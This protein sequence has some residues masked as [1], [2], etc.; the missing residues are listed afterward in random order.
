[1]NKLLS[2]ILL[3]V[4]ASCTSKYT[5][6][7]FEEMN[8]KPW[9]D[10]EIVQ[11]NKEDPRAAYIPY[12]SIDQA[13]EDV[14]WNSPLLQTLN[15]TWKFHLSQN[16]GER[17][18]WFFKDDY[19][20]RDWDEIEVPS[21]WEVQGFDYPIYT[22]VDYP[23]AKTPP[24]I[25][26]NYNPVGSYKRT[27][28]IPADWD[29]K[30]IYLHFGAASSCLSVW[31]N[32]QYVGYSEDSKTPAEFNVTNVIKEGKNSLAVEIHRWS[33][34]SYLEDQD[35]WRLSGITRDSYVMARNKKHI[36]DFRV[37]STLDENYQNGVF[38]LTVDL[39]NLSEEQTDVTVDAELFDG[40]QSIQKFSEKV[41]LAKIDE[42]T[43]F[44]ALIPNVKAWTAETPNLY[45]L[46]IS[47]KDGEGNLIEVVR[48]DVGFR[49]VEIKNSQLM[50]NGKPIYVK[51]VNLHEHHDVNGHVVDKETMLKDIKTMKMHNI[52][53]VRTSHYPQ[54]EEWYKLCNIYGLYLIDEANIESHGMGYGDESLAKNPLWGKA[55]LYRTKNL[56]ERD[57][58]Q[59][60][61][62]IWSLGNEAGN[63]INFM[64]DYK[65]LKEIDGTRPVQYEQ[66]HGGENTD[67][68][69]P[70]YARM[71]GMEK[72]AKS[73]P[74]KPL[75]QCEYAHAMGNSV[76]NL[77]DYW[78]L[79]E[80]YDVLQGGCIWDWVD[81]G[82]LTT[83][84]AGEEFWAYGGD[85]G[86]D[87]VPSDGNFCN[88]GLVDPD[89][90]VKPQLLEVKKVYQNVGF[91][92]INL[93][94]GVFE[95]ANKYVFT[96][97]DKY[98][99]SWNISADG[100]IVNDGKLEG[101][102]LAAL[103][104][105]KV[106][107][108]YAIDPKPGTEYFVTFS[109]KTK[110][111]ENLVP[112][113][114]EMAGEQMELPIYKSVSIIEISKFQ[115]LEIKETDS[116][117]YITGDRFSLSFDKTEGVLKSFKSGEEEMLMSG[118][119]PNFWRA[120]IDN[121][122]GNNLHKRSR[123][124]RKAG[125]NRKVEE[126][127]LTK[128]SGNKVQ[129]TFKFELNDKDASKIADYTSTYTIYG[130]GDIVVEN[131]F[132]MAND[133]LP[134]IVRMGMNLV[135]PREFDQM[136]WFGRGPQESYAD[137]KTGAFVGLYSG[138]VADQYWAYLRPQENGNKTDVRWMTITNESGTGLLFVGE[139]LLSVSAHHNIMEDF[140]SPDRT[141][142]RHQKG[143]KPVHRH[144]NDVKPRDLTS[145]NIDDKQ[146]GVG[147]DDSWGAWTHD[148][149]RLTKKAY[150]YSF[151][152]K[153]IGSEDNPVELAKEKF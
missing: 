76:G 151:R 101:F 85:F 143:V 4:L 141:D 138:A 139:P 67:I 147:G 78:D 21:N 148:Q 7:P 65:F 38:E 56:F 27:F 118:P 153:A 73:N 93:S 15:G 132:K 19:D 53:T 117:V 140:E 61:V 100:K 8:P 89:R 33:D 121:D 32:E 119:I 28:E 48:Q 128:E 58:N 133:E 68:N 110:K 123:I 127:K 52:N 120:P 142:G 62:I 72:Y 81:Q 45:K 2:V 37:I 115:S 152:I 10:P 97:L 66:A 149:Y 29:G 129:L 144:I 95:I 125:E 47:L 108:D 14:M 124:W 3:F 50:V 49:T 92:A 114:Y 9:E 79:I 57:K 94:K 87:T 74:E 34:A 17:P 112:A 44:K 13:N 135:M 150:S 71:E 113:D 75:I 88:N 22:N 39:A 106:N 84:E 6:V 137:R 20:T 12:T 55:H 116:E 90:A 63:G 40:D 35:F 26:E 25:Q 107:I 99:I 111:E 54:P 131:Q 70:M 64:A 82:L 86:P 136:S 98:D 42:S 145:V 36:D 126:A 41:A 31:V 103:S 23:H 146:M 77:Q 130:S 30:E 24:L 59:P 80:S 96:N 51:G 5:D 83:D 105:K 60:S 102:E 43:S 18:Y 109:V 69:C 104:T 46:L 122:F 11:I 91:K 1:M 134:E 16:P